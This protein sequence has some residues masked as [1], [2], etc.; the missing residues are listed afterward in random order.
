MLCSAKSADR[1]YKSQGPSSSTK[2]QEREKN[3]EL[4]EI[5]YNKKRGTICFVQN[6]EIN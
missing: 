5:D 2:K 3:R 6:V 1:S 4:S